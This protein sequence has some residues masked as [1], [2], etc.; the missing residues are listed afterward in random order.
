MPRRSLGGL[1]AWV[2]ET[3]TPLFVV[4]AE[5][6]VLF[7]NHGCEALTGWAAADVVGRTCCFAGDPEVERISALTG[8]LCPPPHALVGTPLWQAVAVPCRSGEVLP[9]MGVFVPLPAE[10]GQPLRVLGIWLEPVANAPVH[11]LASPLPAELVRL[12]H[13]LRRRCGSDQVVARSS[14]MQRVVTQIELAAGSRAPVHVRGPRGSGREFCARVIHERSPLGERPFVPLDCA[15][16]TPFELRRT[17]TRLL[18]PELGKD[19]SPPELRPSG[20]CLRDVTALPRELQQ[21]LCE[22]W[23]DGSGSEPPPLRLYSTAEAP[24]E[25]AAADGRLLPEL[26]YRL[27][28]LTLVLPPLRERADDLP[29]L[30]QLFVEQANQAGARQVAGVEPAALQLLQRYN[31]PGQVRELQAVIAEAHAAADGPHVLVAHLPFRF[32]AGLDAQRQAPP[33]TPAAI[34]LEQLLRDVEVREIRRALEESAGNRSRAARRL[35]L[36]RPKLYRR[37]EQLGLAESPPATAED[38]PATAEPAPAVS[39]PGADASLPHELD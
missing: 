12:R 35:G 29:L 27:S 26:M 28:P 30:V 9:R 37:L 38:S 13:D 36:T 16:L 20:L 39:H 21:L 32:R 17:L 6:R 2:K 18:R 25:D 22:L 14:A 33:R 7:F 19:D 8:V 11:P 23:P 1:P 4:D 15:A 3:T 34:N 31:W 10:H 24:L 5:C